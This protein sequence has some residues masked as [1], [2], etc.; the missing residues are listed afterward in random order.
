MGRT[1]HELLIRGATAADDAA[2]ADMFNAAH[3]EFAGIAVRTAADIAWR[4]RRQPGMPDDGGII[5]EAGDGRIVGYAFVKTNG[6]VTEFA[7]APGGQRHEAA[8]SLIAACEEHALGHGAPH[9]RVNLPNSDTAVAGALEAA[10][11]ASA[12][13]PGRRYVASVDPGRLAR[14]LAAGADPPGR[15]EVIVTDPYPWQSRVTTIGEGRVVQIEAG[16]G[17]FNEILLAG[18]S[19]WRA[20]LT[21]RLRV[22]SLGMTGPAVRFLRRIQVSAPWFHTLG[23]VL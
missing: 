9:V 7:L 21:G 5:V 18:A 23:D 8:A 1:G 20:I 4:C 17:T 22:R 14:A 15:V 19:P 10:G 6:D 3:A 2:L 13:A 11:W 16:Q 12:P